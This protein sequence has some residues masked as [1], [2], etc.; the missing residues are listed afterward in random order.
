MATTQKGNKAEA[1]RIITTF[2]NSARTATHC[3]IVAIQQAQTHWIQAWA[4]H[5]PPDFISEILWTALFCAMAAVP[6]MALAGGLSYSLLRK[7]MSARGIGMITGGSAGREFQIFTDE[8]ENFFASYKKISDHVV[9]Y[10]DMYS[11]GS[12]VGRNAVTRI[13]SL[14]NFNR[15]QKPK[16][17]TAGVSAEQTIDDFIQQ[18]SQELGMW[19]GEQNFWTKMVDDYGDLD[20]IDIGFKTV[21]ASINFQPVEKTVDKLLGSPSLLAFTNQTAL[22]DSFEQQLWMNYVANNVILRYDH[23][24]GGNYQIQ[25]GMEQVQLDH[26]RKHKDWGIQTAGDLVQWGATV[27]EVRQPPSPRFPS[28]P[29]NSPYRRY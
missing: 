28:G 22:A 2:F 5:D 27:Y 11:L 24:D 19:D 7:T 9:Q 26:I 14:T 16:M 10:K 15:N 12:D 29:G 20:R 8:T 13:Q 1:T 17:G 18:F 23:F 3:K 6:G 4:Q 25:E 21:W